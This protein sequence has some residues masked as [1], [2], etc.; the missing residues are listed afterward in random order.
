[1]E[2]ETGENCLMLGTIGQEL[3]KIII[4]SYLAYTSVTY[5]NCYSILQVFLR[6][7]LRN[8]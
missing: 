5:I 4:P 6:K 1:M 2:G 8:F 7:F 3:V